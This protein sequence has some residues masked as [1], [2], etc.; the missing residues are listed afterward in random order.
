M[1][2]PNLEHLAYLVSSSDICKFEM[3][4]YLSVEKD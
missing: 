4:Q 1:L 3:I 2:P